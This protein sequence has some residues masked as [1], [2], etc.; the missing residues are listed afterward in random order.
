VSCPGARSC[1]KGLKYC[2][3][4]CWSSPHMCIHTAQLLKCL[5]CMVAAFT[6][7]AWSSSTAWQLLV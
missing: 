4:V 5:C 6:R 1:R 2:L 7:D 3:Q